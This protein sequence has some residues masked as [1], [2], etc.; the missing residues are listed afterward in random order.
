MSQTALSSRFNDVLE[1]I[2]K[3]SLDD[4][5]ALIEIVRQRLIEQRRIDLAQDI[6]ETREA[7]QKGEVQ[8]GSVADLMKALD[9]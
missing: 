8:R 2:E 4:Q 9:L 5:T 3:W 7:Y 1:T 6:K